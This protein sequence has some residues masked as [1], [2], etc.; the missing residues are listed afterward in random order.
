M[1]A[2]ACKPFPTLTARLVAAGLLAIALPLAAQEATLP[3]TAWGGPDF[4]GTWN[5]SDPTPLERPPRY[6]DR[7]FLTD[8]ELAAQA[9]DFARRQQAADAREAEVARRVL[10]E[11]TAD[12]GAFNRFWNDQ[13]PPGLNPRTS[14]IVYPPDGR[15]PALTDPANVQRSSPPDNPCF[16][17]LADPGR[18]VRISYGALSCDRPEDFALATRCLHWPQTGGP[19]TVGNAYNNNILIVQTRDDVVIHAEMGNAPRIVPLDGRPFADPRLVSWTGSS[20][21]WFEGE[22]LVV[23]T[24]NVSHQVASLFFRAVAYGDASQRVLTER[25]TPLNDGVL[26]YEYTI[27]DPATFSDRLI[28]RTRMSRLN[29]RMFEYACHE[30]NYALTNML[31]AARLTEQ[32][33]P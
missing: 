2:D 10:D 8:E 12:T 27:D 30:G 23:E 28:V 6:G 9:E 26:E 31:R 22:T 13:E 7:E 29:E 14:Q 19:H 1:K 20:R 3:R 24:R 21:G 17:G 25:F 5:F 16:D 4:T 15:L 33:G 32:Q 18:P 11:P